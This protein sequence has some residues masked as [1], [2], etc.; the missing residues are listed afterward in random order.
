MILQKPRCAS[1]HMSFLPALLAVR[2][3][4]LGL[5]PFAIIFAG[6]TGRDAMRIDPGSSLK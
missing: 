2:P 6:E 5:L 4:A 3:A 1:P